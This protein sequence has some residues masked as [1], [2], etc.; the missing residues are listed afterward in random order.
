MEQIR[1]ILRTE[2]EDHH[3]LFM[4]DVDNFKM[5][6]DTY[7]HQTGD[8]FL[9]D[10]TAKIKNSFR[11]EDVVGRIGGDE[12]FVLMRNIPDMDIV[13][14]KAQDILDGIKNIIGAFY[15]PKAVLVDT[16]LLSSLPKRQISNGLAEAVKMSLTSDEKLFEKFEKYSY[17]E[18]LRNLEEIIIA[19][20]QIK[21]DVV[22]KDEKD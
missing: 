10:L 20:L 7:G 1:E 2:M 6:N 5:L 19:S 14:K 21:K 18:I 11:S 4:I 8:E 13:L 9:V 17:E 15:Q 12:F 16:S 3:V 22:E